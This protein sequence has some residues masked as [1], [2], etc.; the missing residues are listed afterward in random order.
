MHIF[1][2]RHGRT[3]Y[4]DL[5]LCNSDPS[6]DVHLT[7]TG[8]HQSQELAEKLKHAS[9]TDIYTSELKRTQQTAAII[10]Q[11]HH[12]ELH[13]DSRLN[14][15]RT[16]YEGQPATK[17]YDALQASPDKWTVRFND[18]ESWEDVKVRVQDFLDDLQAQPYDSVL[19][20]TS[21]VIIQIMCGLVRRLTNDQAFELHIDQ[22]TYIELGI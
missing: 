15:N 11:Y 17:Y 14:D 6:V 3:N 13:T 8:K 9:F 2:A 21:M 4:N 22:G 1:L 19:I 5:D 12:A 7:E 16:G 10:N 18:G 20:V